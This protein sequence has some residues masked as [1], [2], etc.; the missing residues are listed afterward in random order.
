MP[1]IV[2]VDWSQ[3]HLVEVDP[4]IQS[5]APVLRGTR[6]P[7][8]AI[9]DNAQYGLSVMEISEQFEVSQAEVED[10]LAYAKDHRIADIAR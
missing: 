4:E 5:G 2:Q 6:L 7:V 1:A 8:S 3:C 10:I 9:V